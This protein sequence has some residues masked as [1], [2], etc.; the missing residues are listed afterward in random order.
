[1]FLDYYWIARSADKGFRKFAHCGATEIRLQIG[2]SDLSIFEDINVIFS[3]ALGS[4]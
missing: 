3:V 2:S 1:M 4:D